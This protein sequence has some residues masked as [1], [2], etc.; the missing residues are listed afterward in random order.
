MA[1]GPPVVLVAHLDTVGADPAQWATNPF[2]LVEEG[3]YL[4]GRGVIDDKGM[5]AAMVASFNWLIDQPFPRSR[6]VI[7]ILTADEE[8]GGE[9]GTRWLIEN[10]RRSTSARRW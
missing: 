1:V 4:R 10:G 7:L 5:A 3:R 9:K 6:E 2:E 8:A